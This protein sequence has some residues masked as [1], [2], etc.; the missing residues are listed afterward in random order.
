MTTTVYSTL[1]WEI[2]GI[3]EYTAILGDKGSATIVAEPGSTMDGVWLS[4]SHYSLTKGKAVNK[5]KAALLKKKSK[6]EADI[7][8]FQ[9]RINSLERKLKSIEK[10]LTSDL[11]GSDECL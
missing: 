3:R 9:N 5:V 6:L 7:I 2:F 8:S 4:R 10:W 11:K 1:Y